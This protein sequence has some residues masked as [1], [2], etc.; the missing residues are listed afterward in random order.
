MAGGLSSAAEAVASADTRSNAVPSGD[1]SLHR[2]VIVHYH[3]TSQLDV[4]PT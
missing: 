4:T 1:R 3:C 2:G